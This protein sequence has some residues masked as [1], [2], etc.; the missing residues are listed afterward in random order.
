MILVPG[1]GVKG[2]FLMKCLIGIILLKND[3]LTPSPGTKIP[4][5]SVVLKRIKLGFHGGIVPGKLLD[6]YFLYFAGCN[7]KLIV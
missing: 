4:I 5:D 2:S 3:P 7:T 6:A 1:D